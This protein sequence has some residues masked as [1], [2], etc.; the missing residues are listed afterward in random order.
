MSSF[1]RK[2]TDLIRSSCK[3]I[4]GF[5]IYSHL[6][7]FLWVCQLSFYLEAFAVKTFSLSVEQNFIRIDPIHDKLFNNDKKS[8]KDY[9]KLFFFP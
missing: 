2:I 3:W 9:K 1:S 6:D 8:G 7:S 4:N 5:I